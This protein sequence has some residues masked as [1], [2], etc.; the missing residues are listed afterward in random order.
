LKSVQGSY[1]C[2]F[3]IPL[4]AY[5]IISLVVAASD[6]NAIGK[7][8][9]MP[10]HLPNDLKHFK[11]VTW[12]LPVVMGR[13]TFDSLGKPLPGRKNIVITRTAGWKHDNA[14]GVKSIEDAMF[15]A[16][17]MDVKE[18]MVIG[19]GEIYKLLFEKAKRI[20][21]TRVNAEFEADTFFPAIDE[22]LWQLISSDTYQ[23]DEKN[24]YDHAFQLWE[25]IK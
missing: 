5:M 14:I 3:F 8:G 15:L 7:D 9:K 10:W 6:N 16:K 13:K 2:A 4:P 24:N 19:G 21:L 20:Y 23:T 12:G 17:Q 1:L 22:K 11:N 18:L 25:R